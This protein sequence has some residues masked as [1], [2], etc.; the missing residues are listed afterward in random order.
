MNAQKLQKLLPAARRIRARRAA[1]LGRKFVHLLL[2]NSRQHRHIRRDG[3]EKNI[4]HADEQR[5][6]N[7]H[8]DIV[9]AD[10]GIHRVRIL[11][12]ARHIPVDERLP[13]FGE[14]RVGEA[15]QNDR[16]ADVEIRDDRHT[17]CERR[18]AGECLTDA[19]KLARW[20]GVGFVDALKVV[21][22]THQRRYLREKGVLA[23]Y[24]SRKR[25]KKRALKSNISFWLSRGRNALEY[26]ICRLRCI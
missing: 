3:E 2:R 6:E 24:L 18:D 9:K 1:H 13:L 14:I 26:Q 21:D 11:V 20:C 12:H 17:R 19:V 16:H 8:D 4:T 10:G 15:G 22:H 5:A 23:D 25:S 7:R